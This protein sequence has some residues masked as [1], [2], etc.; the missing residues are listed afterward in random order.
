[1]NVLRTMNCLLAGALLAGMMACSGDDLGQMADKKGQL[2]DGRAANL[3]TQTVEVDTVGGLKDKMIELM[4][5]EASSVQKLTIKGPI[6][7]ADWNYVRSLYELVELDLSETKFESVGSYSAYRSSYAM[8]NDTVNERMFSSYDYYDGS[9]FDKLETVKL[10][11]TIRRI[12]AYAFNYC[13]SLNYIELPDSTIVLGGKAFENCE[14]LDSIKFNEKLRYLGDCAFRY[15]YS[16]KK[17][18]LPASLYTIYEYAFYNCSGLETVEFKSVGDGTISHSM[19]KGCTSLKS[20]VLPDDL[21]TI[22]RYAFENCSSLETITL[23]D[24]LE[25]IEYEA[26]YKCSSLSEINI[27]QS[28]NSLGNEVFRYCSSLSEINIPQSVSSLGTRVF[29]YCSSLKTVKLLANVTAIPDYFFRQCTSLVSVE[30]ASTI[31]SVGYQAFAACRA[32]NDDDAFSNINKIGDSGFEDSGFETF[33]LSNVTNWGEVV[34][35]NSKKLKSVVFPVGI[36]TLANGLFEGCNSMISIE[37]PQTLETI[38]SSVFSGTSLTSIDLPSSLKTIN[39]YAF[40]NT[41]LKELTIPSSVTSVSDYFVNNCS[42]LVA[43]YWNSSVEVPRNSGTKSCLVYLADN[44]MSYNSDS[45]HNVIAGDVAEIIELGYDGGTSNPYRPS[46]TFACP[47][48]FTAKKVRYKRTFDRETVPGQSAGWQTIT[49][50]FTPD[51]IYHVSKGAIAPFNSGIEGAKPFWLREL[52]AEGFTDVTSIQPHTAYLIAMPNNSQ[53]LDQYRLNGTIVFEADSVEFGVT[54]DTLLASV[55][56]DFEFQPTYQK[57][58]KAVGVYALDIDTRS[59]VNNYYTSGTAFTRNSEPVYTFEAYVKTLGG[60]RSS[61]STF[62]IDGRS[63]NTRSA[64]QPNKT[65][66]P[67]IGD[68]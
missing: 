27:P 49:L 2:E 7:G 21:K 65:G 47:K 26:F 54:P 13:K 55:G 62:E 28:V 20:V 44:T 31:T 66:I 46:T 8:K 1:M 58:E 15:C 9:C 22:N 56:P 23:P 18:S 42:N 6:S 52:T 53:Y 64:D 24:G 40:A 61:R 48:P 59:Y 57:L 34:F 38:G 51:S 30:L 19:F 32:L 63:K 10:P 67:Q 4:G 37:L 16:L 68:M 25:T 14:G 36:K 50:P 45:W 43:L 35:R 33:D 60:G 11:E 12:E 17:V 3:I 39:G 29:E 5:E 41:P